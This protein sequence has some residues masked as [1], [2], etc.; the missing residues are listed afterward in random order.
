MRTIKLFVM[1]LILLMP[2][3]GWSSPHQ[4]KPVKN[5][6]ILIPDG[7]SVGA[8]TL[9]RWFQGGQ[10][11]ALDEMAAGL[12]RTYNS[13]TPIGDSAPAGSAFATGYKSQT[14]QIASRPVKAG[15]PGVPPTPPGQ[16]AQHG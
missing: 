10:P 14:G 13:D 16:A 12:V 3:Y 2:A 15:M 5:V 7:M 4:V 11:L 8:T 6:I 1:S 9:A